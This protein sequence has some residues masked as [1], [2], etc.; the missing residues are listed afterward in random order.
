MHSSD[1]YIVSLYF[2]QLSL[3]L[4]THMHPAQNQTQSHF[5]FID[6]LVFLDGVEDKVA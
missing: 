5:P 1:F 3:S 2:S 4:H 6:I